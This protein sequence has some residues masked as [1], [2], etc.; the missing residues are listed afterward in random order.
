LLMAV[1]A[2]FHY[3]DDNPD[4]ETFRSR[5]RGY[6]TT[7]HD[8]A[9]TA[10]FFAANIPQVL[11]FNHTGDKQEINN[12]IAEELN[13]YENYYMLD[14]DFFMSMI[15]TG[16]VMCNGEIVD[17]SSIFQDLLHL[18]D[19]GHQILA[20]LYI[21]MLNET[22]PNLKLSNYREVRFTE[23]SETP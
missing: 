16:Q 18:N 17:P 19:Y 12:I 2:F 8:I 14:I 21:N 3:L 23:P 15:L 6:L 7:I 4:S 10:P 13:T 22:Y 11:M 5:V 20:D 1:D 9:P